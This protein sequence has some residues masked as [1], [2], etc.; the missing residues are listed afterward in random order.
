MVYLLLTYLPSILCGVHVVRTRQETYWIWL[1]V[2]APGLGPLIYFFAV[3]AP[4]MFGGR[5]ARRVGSAAARA[6][7]PQREY[8][9]AKQALEDTPTIGN[10]ARIADAAL[11]LGRAEEAEPLYRDA[12]VGQFADDPAI[13]MGHTRALLEL[14]RYQ[15]ALA[16]VERLHAQN[17]NDPEIALAYARAYEGLDRLDDADAPYRFAADRIPGLEGAARYVAFM[18]KAGRLADARTGLDEL[19]RRLPKI[20]A[21]FRAE[22]RRWRDY[23]AQA[24]ASAS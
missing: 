4:E 7:D 20:P 15:E 2:I 24:V 5:T 17:S 19:N 3:I 10:R 6:M 11:A 12:L 18:A 16:Q 23:A 8:R 13:L 1:L 22:A 9:L 14:G 21:H